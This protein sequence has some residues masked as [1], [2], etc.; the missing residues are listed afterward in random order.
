MKTMNSKKTSGFGV[1]LPALLCSVLAA[2][3][4]HSAEIEPPKVQLVDK[5]GVNMANGQVTHSM[6]V[7]SI[8]GPMGLSDSISIRANEFDFNGYRGF[9][10]KYYAKAKN[11]E[12]C[13]NTSC[14]PRNLM[15]VYDG[16]GSADFAYY[17]GGV[18]QQD[19]SAISNYSY[20]PI[21]DER[22]TLEAIGNDLVW[23]KPD[24]TEVYFDRST[25]TP[26]PASKDGILTRIVYPNG[27]TVTVTL[28]GVSVNTNTGFQLKR[29][30][31]PDTRPIDKA[32]H[33]AFPS[34]ADSEW[35]AQNP[36]YVYGVNAAVAWCSWTA[37][38]CSFSQTWPKATF[39]WPPAMPRTMKIGT[40]SVNVTTAQGI[41][42]TYGFT[43]YDL[44]YND[45][46]QVVPGFTAGVEFSPRMTS[47]SAPNNSGVSTMTY[48]YKN[49]FDYQSDEFG[50][51]FNRRLQTSGVTKV[52]NRGSLQVVYDAMRPY[53]TDYENAAT[54]IN[55]LPFVRLRS[56]VS[57]AQGAINFVDTQDGRITFEMSARN[58]P[59][60]YDKTSSPREVYGYTRSNLTSVAYNGHLPTGFSVLAEYPASCT[61]STRKTC[62]QVTR[63][64]DANGNWT[65]YAYHSASGEVETVTLPANKHGVRAQ[66]RYQYEQKTAHYYDA[67]GTW[68]TGAPIWL[69]T[70][71]EYCINSAASG[72]SCAGGDEVV[73]QYEYNHNNLLLT[74]MTVTS[75]SGVR[76]VCYRYDIYGNQIGVTTPNANLGSCP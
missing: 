28:A 71:E 18:L 31:E 42:T 57:G 38:T 36:K 3:F 7:V 76:R 45:A 60:Q 47:V 14:S 32:G 35:S 39:D 27:F 15:R 59:V 69:K 75:P 64:R 29:V 5:F 63:I 50:G 51:S 10:H 72:G 23:I 4:V 9:N 30:Y 37:S 12:L 16:A 22:H 20:V 58:F 43:A 6:E 25:V 34:S 44:A 56:S 70:V 65:D 8:G 1:R 68:I 67:T 53:Q 61:P 73:T 49:M 46:G 41:T 11:V 52:A 19:G 33:P 2:T 21:G 26:K 62:N 66:T 55:G 24:G 17:V 13:T 74:G 48:D 54:G 40:T